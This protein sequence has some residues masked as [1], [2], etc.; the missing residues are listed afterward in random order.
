MFAPI[1]Q[2]PRG[3]PLCGACKTRIALCPFCRAELSDTRNR[4]L[5][6]LAEG[7][8]A[9]CRH[10]CGA[11]LNR[12]E[13]QT[14]E[15]KLCRMRPGASQQQQQQQQEQQ[16]ERKIYDADDLA[17]DS[18]DGVLPVPRKPAV[19][20]FQAFKMFTAPLDC[21]IGGLCEDGNGDLLL[22][23]VGS[24]CVRRLDPLTSKD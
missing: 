16:T 12:R 5:E 22:T 11:L 21:N 14:H 6:L 4:G 2:C 9:F 7:L 24:N 23:D 20:A 13:R 19:R 10:G 15:D 18:K 17:L 3:H 1:Y 8:T